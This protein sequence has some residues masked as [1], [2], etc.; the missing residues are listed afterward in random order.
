MTC[1][2]LRQS[3]HIWDDPSMV[4]SIVTALARNLVMVPTAVLRR[5]VAKDA[6]VL[7]LRH[8]NAVLRRQT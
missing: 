1:K 7:A 4:L 6:E 2:L 3:P 8:E 5:R